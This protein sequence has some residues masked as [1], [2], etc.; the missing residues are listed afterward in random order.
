MSDS[1]VVVLPRA[2]LFEFF[3]KMALPPWT[4]EKGKQIGSRIECA[5]IASEI[6]EWVEQHEIVAEFPFAPGLIDALNDLTDKYGYAGIQ[7][8]LAR[9][10]DAP[11]SDCRYCDG[12]GCVACD[13]RHLPTEG[14]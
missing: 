4:D 11:D 12:A 9:T 1:E 5:P 3:G 6:A 2:A 10:K 7:H 8:A 13:A 14:E